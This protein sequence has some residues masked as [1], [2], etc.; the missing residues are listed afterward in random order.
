M[1]IDWTSELYTAYRLQTYSF[2]RVL[3]EAINQGEYDCILSLAVYF[4]DP[5]IVRT[6]F[7]NRHKMENPEAQVK[8][9]LK[10]ALQHNA[11]NVCKCILF[12]I[13]SILG[14]HDITKSIDSEFRPIVNCLMIHYLNDSANDL[15]KIMRY[16]MMSWEIYDDKYVLRTDYDN[17]EYMGRLI[18]LMVKRN[19]LHVM[20]VSNVT[21]LWIFFCESQKMVCPCMLNQPV[22]NHSVK[23][24]KPK[25]EKKERKDKDK[26]DKKKY[27]YH[28]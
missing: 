11:I 8:V 22:V 21:D 16:E 6:V 26:K 7:I 27:K 4:D 10:L 23:K 18:S 15:R 12:D 1:S 5:E 20:S 13:L 25:K 3:R 14:A 19:I 17:M 9:T 2:P 24:S 28:H